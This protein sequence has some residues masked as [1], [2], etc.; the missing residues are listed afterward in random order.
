V[1]FTQNMSYTGLTWT[2]LKAPLPSVSDI[3]SVSIGDEIGK[4]TI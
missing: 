1:N 2:K 4:D 3:C